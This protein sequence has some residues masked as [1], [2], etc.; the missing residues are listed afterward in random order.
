[1]SKN[2]QKYLSQDCS[3]DDILVKKISDVNVLNFIENQ[4]YFENA[5]IYI[6][7]R[8]KLE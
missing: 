7:E 6:I 1:M 4:N 5:F 3:I 8:L 2:I